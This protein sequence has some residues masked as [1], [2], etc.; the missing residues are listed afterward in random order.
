[1]NW[2]TEDSARDHSASKWQ[3]KDLNPALGSDLSMLGLCFGNLKTAWRMDFSRDG[4]MEAVTIN[5]QIFISSISKLFLTVYPWHFWGFCLALLWTPKS[6]YVAPGNKQRTNPSCGPDPGWSARLAVIFLP[7]DVSKCASN[8]CLSR[9][10]NYY[11]SWN[12]RLSFF[13]IFETLNVKLKNTKSVSLATMLIRTTSS[14]FKMYRA[15]SHPSYRLS[16]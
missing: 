8:L 15:V 16:G 1:M 6:L 11:R 9:S 3:T 13:L 10:S 14:Y 2:W 5:W 4:S 7:C 12:S